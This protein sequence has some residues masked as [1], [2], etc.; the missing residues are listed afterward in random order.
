MV[1]T[2]VEFV[3]WGV[4]LF[5]PFILNA[6]DWTSTNGPFGGNIC[7]IE[8]DPS[9]PNHILIGTYDAGIFQTIDGGLNWVASDQ[10]I[11]D[12]IPYWI[13][14]L[15]SSADGN[16][17]FAITHIPPGLYKSTDAGNT[18]FHSSNGIILTG[19][20]SIAID[21]DSANLVY[22]TQ[23][24]DLI[25]PYTIWKSTNQGNS[26][27]ALTSYGAAAAEK[28]IIDPNSTA[29][30]YVVGSFETDNKISKSTDHGATWFSADSNL[31]GTYL[32][33][34]KLAIDPVNSNNLYL[35]YPGNT[36]A[37]VYKTT[38]AGNYW[39]GTD[40]G[41]PDTGYYWPGGIA[42]HPLNNNVIYAD[43]YFSWDYTP[44]LYRSGHGGDN[45]QLTGTGY[46]KGVNDIVFD[47]AGNG[48]S[49]GYDVIMTSDA[50][51]TW[52]TR[53]N[54]IDAAPI[55]CLC[56]DQQ[57]GA[58][59]A[60]AKHIFNGRG[61]GIYKRIGSV[62]LERNIGIASPRAGVDAI[63]INPQNSSIVYAAS[64]GL[65]YKS[66]NGGTSWSDCT[67]NLPSPNKKITDI[68]IDRQGP[69]VIY[70]ANHGEAATTGK[71]EIYQSTDN[72]LTW[73]KMTGF[74]FDELIWSG[75]KIG[76]D[77]IDTLKMYACFNS[78]G[79][80]R[81]FFRS[82]DQGKTWE[83][84][85]D[86][87]ISGDHF[88]GP[89]VVDALNPNI[90]YL[91]Y[92]N[93]FGSLANT[94]PIFKSTDYG[95]TWDSIPY[96]LPR[97]YEQRLG[98]G[99]ITF[100]DIHNLYLGI[101]NAIFANIGDVYKSTNEGA[102]WAELGNLNQGVK[103]LVCADNI[104]YA[105]T[106]GRSV[107]AYALATIEETTESTPLMSKIQPSIIRTGAEIE[108]SYAMSKKGKLKIALFDII[109]RKVATIYQGSAQSGNL[110]IA[111]QTTNIPGGIYFII[112][113]DEL[114][115]T[116][117]KVVIL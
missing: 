6:A 116:R 50:G 1:K 65:L 64:A 34:H 103:G 112:I 78:G 33:V 67:D 104:L 21:P 40:T 39:F 31:P 76:L 107:W 26:W 4:V 30:L 96:G 42:V 12:T 56:V 106:L 111:W 80:G 11:S 53:S 60:G 98:C 63:A 14:D 89:V 83:I 47:N 90:I 71:A 79:P 93:M 37:R 74:D 75:I 86:S 20:R 23:W 49:Y 87:L 85:W 70:V 110:N 59:Y 114:R 22:Y 51:E 94:S 88:L 77:P 8:K 108:I 72:G 82:L 48:F 69:N 18:W 68:A 28:I 27:F 113:A 102:T 57:T 95:A 24:T 97:D 9:N 41:F 73:E 58:I 44:R 105:G 36:Y 84:T 81:G 16:V 15:T 45:W 7:S 38:D 109:G 35:G 52:Q 117:L 29:T 10:G 62:W 66:T 17:W 61:G 54:G 32:L 99:G 101:N 91:G 115:I 5:F 100:D 3:L 46:E 19:P 92:T 2:K 43:G 55:T 13:Y 25:S